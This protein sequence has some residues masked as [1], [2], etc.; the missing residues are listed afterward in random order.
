MA[1]IVALVAEPRHPYFEQPVINGTVGIMA[2][3]AIVKNRRM[4]EE[5]GAAPF[6]VAAIAVLVDAGLY[7]LSGIR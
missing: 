1:A 5:K 4:L 6:A 2:V 3:G 7:E